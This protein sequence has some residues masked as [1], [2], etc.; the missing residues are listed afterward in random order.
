[1]VFLSMF[2]KLLFSHIRSI[3]LHLLLSFYGKAEKSLVDPLVVGVVSID[4]PTAPPRSEERGIHK[5][6]VEYFP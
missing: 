3:F 6:V 5:R 4:A 1:M 2:P